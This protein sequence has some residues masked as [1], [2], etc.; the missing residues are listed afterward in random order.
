MQ[1]ESSVVKGRGGRGVGVGGESHR[2]F[3]CSVFSKCHQLE[4][5]FWGEGG[6]FATQSTLHL[7][8]GVLSPMTGMN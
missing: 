5:G 1:S 7:T 4:D 2:H 3:L 8:S 6:E